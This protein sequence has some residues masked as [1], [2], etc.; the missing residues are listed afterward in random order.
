ML[1]KILNMI[2]V[3]GI[4]QA[5]LLFAAGNIID[6]G[7]EVEESDETGESDRNRQ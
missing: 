2:K 5:K 4:E 3:E 1:V 7:N 6:E